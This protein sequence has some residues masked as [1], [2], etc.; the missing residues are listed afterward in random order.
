MEDKKN[1]QFIYAYISICIIFVLIGISYAVARGDIAT[2]KEKVSMMEKDKEQ[3]NR[4]EFNLRRLLEKE[5]MEY[6]DFGK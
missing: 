2:L 5:G 4:I 1:P 3:L 6:K